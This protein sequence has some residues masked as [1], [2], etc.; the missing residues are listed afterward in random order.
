MDGVY[1]TFESIPDVHLAVE[2]LD[3]RVGEAHPELVSVQNVTTTAG[4]V[5]YA[6]V[7]V[8]DGTLG[9]FVSRLQQYAET[10]EQDKPRNRN[11]VD[12]IQAIG[13]ATIKTLWTDPPGAF[14]EPTAT[15]WWEVWL[16]RRDGNEVGRFQ[17]FAQQAGVRLGARTLGFS[18]RI[19]VLAQATAEQ[20]AGALGVLRD[21]S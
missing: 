20:L 1:L 8:P 11:L 5:E 16:R 9:Y 10:A 7:F 13:L 18:E 4:V 12:R 3:P 17:E 15:V 6:T 14:P 19:V 2:S 21:V